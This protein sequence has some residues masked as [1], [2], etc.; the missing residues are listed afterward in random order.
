MPIHNGTAI[1]EISGAQQERQKA[2]HGER[3]ACLYHFTK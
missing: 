1:P 2:R 3:V